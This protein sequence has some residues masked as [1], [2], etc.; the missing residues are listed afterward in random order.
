MRPADTALNRDAL[1]ALNFRIKFEPTYK[2]FVSC[3]IKRFNGLQGSNVRAKAVTSIAVRPPQ[4]IKNTAIE[5]NREDFPTN[6][7]IRY[8]VMLTI[9]LLLSFQGDI[10]HLRASD[11]RG[12][13]ESTRAH[14]AL[15]C[16]RP[17]PLNAEWQIP[18]VIAYMWSAFAMRH[19]ALY[20]KCTAP[21]CVGILVISNLSSA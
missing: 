12:T 8:D 2:M 5:E 20:M 4:P 10:C 21:R 16:V 11:D 18:A 3:S 6:L 14:S 9:I 17:A 19:V 7:N 1:V 13:C 15:P